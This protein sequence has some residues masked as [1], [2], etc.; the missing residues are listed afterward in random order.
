[1]LLILMLTVAIMT[2]AMLGVARNYRRSIIRDREVEMIHRGEQYERAVRLFYR[3]FS[4]YPNTLEEL[5]NTNKI[6][7]LR[8]RYKDPMT[9]DGTWKLAHL[10][11]VTL[12]GSTGLATAAV[13]TGATTSPFQANNGDLSSQATADAAAAVAAAAANP[14]QSTGGNTTDS[15]S[16]STASGTTGASNF[17]LG[18]ATGSGTGTNNAANG[19]VLGGVVGGVLG[20]VS[21]SKKEGIHSFNDKTHYN[22]WFF[23]YDPGQ[24]KGQLPVG[25]Y[26]PNM[27]LLA[28][29]TGPNPSGTSTTGSTGPA[30]GTG[31]SS[32]T[33]TG[34]GTSTTG[35]PPQ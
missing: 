4:R 5:E 13:A 6:R 29:S 20:V 15:S 35:A 27:Y 10:T 2:I 25:P 31:V 18:S 30:T 3:K 11:D 22:E 16:T 26:N 34:T 17:S 7:F 12:K 21:K 24:D 1:M 14:N 32:A 23:V 33:G 19:Q 28:G 9:K 8:K